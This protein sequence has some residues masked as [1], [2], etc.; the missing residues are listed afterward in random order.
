MFHRKWMLFKKNF[1]LLKP[2]FF[3]KKTISAETFAQPYSLIL[4]L[5]SL[6]A[7]WMEEMGFTFPYSIAEICMHPDL[8]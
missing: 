3:I 6:W 5:V 4:L 7:G 8:F 2:Q 1:I